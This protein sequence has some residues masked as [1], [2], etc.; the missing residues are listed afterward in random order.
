MVETK[1]YILDL[2]AFCKKIEPYVDYYRKQTE[3]YNDTAYHIRKNE[4]DLIYNNY[5]QNKSV[6]SSPH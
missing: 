4:I 6:V 1:K 2:L 5:L 3:S